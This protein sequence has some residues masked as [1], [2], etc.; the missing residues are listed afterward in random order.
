MNNSQIFTV[1]RLLERERLLEVDRK[2]QLKNNGKCYR[3]EHKIC[4]RRVF[5]QH[6]ACRWLS[7]PSI[8]ETQDAWW[9]LLRREVECGRCRVEG[10]FC[11]NK[12]L[13]MKR[14]SKSLPFPRRALSVRN[15]LSKMKRTEETSQHP[16]KRV[17]LFA[18]KTFIHKNEFLGWFREK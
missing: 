13:Y 11:I 14:I 4:D 10:K 15:K 16:S 5:S 18:K 3:R 12:V 17:S 1:G 7:S 6:S 8:R 2:A 9:N